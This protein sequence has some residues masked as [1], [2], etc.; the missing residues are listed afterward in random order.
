MID[1]KYAD[2]TRWIDDVDAGLGNRCD[3]A[4][5]AFRKGTIFVTAKWGA[6]LGRGSDLGVCAGKGAGGA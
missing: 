6:V 4:S 1:A 5:S 2:G 3:D